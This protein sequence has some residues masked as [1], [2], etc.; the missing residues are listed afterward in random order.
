[1]NSLRE[2]LTVKGNKSFIPNSSQKSRRV[3]CY[4][5][6]VL[7][8]SYMFKYEDAEETN[9]IVIDGVE[10]AIRV[11]FSFFFIGHFIVSIFYAQKFN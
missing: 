4:T 10:L 5:H 1:M 8:S 9:G 6:S 3:K 7:G 11:S 2:L